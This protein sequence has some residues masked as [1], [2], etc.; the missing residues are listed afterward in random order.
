VR[1]RAGA[2]AVKREK[3]RASRQDPHRSRTY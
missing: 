1:K 3:K 2:A